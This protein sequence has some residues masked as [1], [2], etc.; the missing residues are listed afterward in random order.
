MSLGYWG[1]DHPAHQGEPVVNAAAAADLL[2]RSG[3]C[4]LPDSR[5]GRYVSWMTSVATTSG[6][7]WP[8]TPR[9]INCRLV[10]G[11]TV[12][13]QHTANHRPHCLRGTK[14]GREKC[15]GAHL[16]P[17]RA[18]RIA[19]PGDRP[20]RHAISPRTRNRRRRIRDRHWASRPLRR[21]PRAISINASAAWQSAAPRRSPTATPSREL[22]RTAAL[23]RQTLPWRHAEPRG[24][25]D[26][27]GLIQSYL[28]PADFCCTSVASYDRCPRHIATLL[29][30]G[31]YLTTLHNSVGT[32]T[33]SRVSYLHISRASRQSR[34]HSRGWSG[35]RDGHGEPR[36]A[37]QGGVNRVDGGQAVVACGGEV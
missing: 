36:V 32:H 4:S 27:D 19:R 29:L 10:S 1:F 23:P 33:Q 15:H 16:D 37:E 8:T 13:P 12:W 17:L 35:P 9:R 24:D 11:T 28:Q 34:V 7:C 25:P 20:R 21:V 30:L 5:S 3:C 6:Q 31:R 26:V 2:T 22:L 14:E 18:V